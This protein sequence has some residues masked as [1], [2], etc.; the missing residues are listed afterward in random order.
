M[1]KSFFREGDRKKRG[2]EHGGNKEECD[3]PK[4]VIFF[5]CF[6]CGSSPSV[7]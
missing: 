6:F 7:R 5:F 1:K 2:V 3:T 4:D